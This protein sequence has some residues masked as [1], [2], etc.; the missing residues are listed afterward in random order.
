MNQAPSRAY[1]PSPF[2]RIG[3]TV[4]RRRRYV[5]V[6]WLVVFALVLPVVLSASKVTSLQQGSATG[7]QLESVRASDLISAQFA[8]EVPNSTLLLVVSGPNVSSSGTQLLIKSL[9]SAVESDGGVVGLNQTSDVYSRLYSTLDGLNAAAFAALDGANASVHLLLGVPALY[10]GAWEQA[11]AGTKNVSAADGIANRTT[12]SALEAANSTAFQTYSSHLLALF[13]SDWSASWTNPANANLTLVERGSLSAA[14]ADSQYLAAYA[15]ASEQFSKA[16]LHAVS[17]AEFTTDNSTQAAAR[18]EGFAVGYVSNK[19]A[20]STTF[21]G[22][23]FG[24]GRSYD[25]SSLYALS[26][27]IVWSPERYDVDQSI[28]TLISSFVSPNRNTTLISLGFSVSSDSNLVAVRSVVSSAAASASPTSPADSVEVTGEDA[29]SYDF[30]NSAQTDLAI[31]LPVTIGLLIVATGLFFRSV[32]TPFITL[33]T[34]GVALGISQVFIV[35]VGTYVAKIDFTIPTVL[36]TVLI[37]V[38]T[39][40]SVFVIARYREERVKG[41]PV[42]QAVETS[43]T[44]AGESIATSGATVIISFLSLSLTSVTFLKTMGIVVGLGILVALAVALTLV[45]AVVSMAG[46]RAFWP[47]SG[48]RFRKYSAAALSKLKGK[49]GY[50]SRSGGFAVKRAKVLI[51]LA[52]LASVPALYVYSTTTP[53][54]DFLSAAPASLESV[55]ASNHLANA[56]GGGKL[57]PTYVVLTFQS[58]LVAH[59]RFNATEMGK[60]ESIS[61][62]LSGSP[63]VRNVT[64]PSRPYG[65]PVPYS[66]LNVSETGDRRIFSTIMTTV[67]KDNRTALVTVNFAIDPYSSAAIGDAQAIR[68]H[69]HSSYGAAGGLTAAYVGGASGSILDTKNVFDSQFSTVV[70]I[71]AFGVALVLLVVLGS[72]FL[73]VFAV[74]SVLMSI[75][76]TL[77]A[78]KLVFQH[79]FNYQILFITPFFLFVTL[80]GLGMDYNIFILTRVREEATRGKSLEE[81]LVSAI[82][83]TGGIIT[84]A[85]VI[86]AGS[87][88]SLMLSSDLLLKQLGFAFA[89]SILIDALVV[90]TYL[91]PAVMATVKRWNWYSPIPFLNRSGALYEQAKRPPEP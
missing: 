85:A 11:Y 78:T 43:V 23:A 26:G 59:N 36:L 44:W 47:T 86:L 50:F 72:L 52:V 10:L 75:V 64:G 3:R 68:Q 15:P 14:E 24:L 81:A 21:V 12:A 32:L 8:K 54:Y 34:I 88:G 66:S 25:N 33:G 19:T 73:P 22:A 51:V 71:V 38:G 63:D 83:Q 6:A 56:F 90:R 20:F 67:G 4:Y 76:W 29:I 89:Y 18:L 61:A 13:D 70:P 77:A 5:L 91:V 87:L 79:F 60:V 82:E 9:V 65:S 27:N 57:Y 28:S 45:P 53:T 2:A 1:R 42:D 40:Y 69:L 58:P 17:F 48:A 55:A 31:I 84:A 46:G 80:L 35:L 62:Y 41:L 30:G 16:A 37:G 74:F 7:A 49:R 39:D